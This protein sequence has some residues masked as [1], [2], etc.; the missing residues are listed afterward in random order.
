MKQTTYDG[1]TLKQR[2]HGCS[3]LIAP[4]EPAAITTRYEPCCRAGYAANL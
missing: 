1:L 4:A 3:E 2:Y